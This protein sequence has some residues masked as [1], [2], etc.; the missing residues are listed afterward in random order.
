VS[1][2]PA[3]CFLH[4]QCCVLSGEATHTNCRV[5]GLT[6]SGFEPTIYHT[7]GEHAN[8]YTT[9]EPTIYHTRGEHANQYTRGE[10]ANQYTRGEHANQYTRSEH[11]NQYTRG[12]HANQYTRGE[13]ANQY[14]RGEHANQ[15]T[16]DTDSPK[17][18]YEI[19]LFFLF[20]QELDK[21]LTPRF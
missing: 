10:H 9:D 18:K 11:A 6:R 12:E 15:Y 20:R 3:H 1:S 19:Y 7:R 21:Q 5:F 2:N 14:T 13:H 4:Q 16:T 8:Q 17:H